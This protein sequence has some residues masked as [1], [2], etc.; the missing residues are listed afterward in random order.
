[1][2]PAIG[3]FTCGLCIK[4]NNCEKIQIFTLLRRGDLMGRITG[5]LNES[6]IKNGEMAR[7]IKV[8]D[9]TNPVISH[10]FYPYLF[11]AN[12][13]ENPEK[14]EIS[15]MEVQLDLLILKVSFSIGNRF[16]ENTL[17]STGELNIKTEFKEIA[18]KLQLKITQT[19]I[20]FPI[21]IEAKTDFSLRLILNFN[22]Y[23]KMNI[24]KLFLI[25]NALRLEA[26]EESNGTIIKFS[27]L[28]IIQEGVN[29]I[30]K[31][32]NISKISQIWF[33]LLISFNPTKTIIR[34]SSSNFLERINQFVIEQFKGLSYF[35]IKIENVKENNLKFDKRLF[36][37]TIPFQITGITGKF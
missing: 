1:M 36:H 29:S 13:L 17:T 9:L 32:K 35:D 7:Q 24:N 6:T 10:V 21:K 5:Q 14:T 37:L 19:P 33:C 2:E 12:Y 20:D 4:A 16:L 28:E 34:E 23:L 30:L 27:S 22:D 31:N 25:N 18:E 11:K 15:S 3:I 26:L 8:Q